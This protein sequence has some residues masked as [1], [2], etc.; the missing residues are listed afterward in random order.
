[1]ET[2]LHRDLKLFYAD[3]DPHSQLEVQLGKWRIDVV[4]GD[5]LIEIQHASLGAIRNKVSALLKHHAVRVV[6]PLPVRRRL[7]KLSEPGGDVTSRR[8]SPKRG[9]PLDLFK[10]LIHFGEVFPHPRLK[11]DVVFC[12]IEEQRYPGHGRRRWRRPGDFIVQDRRLLDV[13][14][15]R[16]LC[17]ASDLRTFAD[18]PRGKAALPRPFDTGQ[19]A[20]ALGIDRWLAQQIAYCWR[21]AGTVSQVGKQGNAWLY[22]FPRRGKKQA[23]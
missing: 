5:E 7:V 14:E 4:R 13:H 6:K 2:S 23:A 16:T 20:T 19:L 9:G 1:M 8:L 17:R 21:N 18:L 10:E 15:I 11:L 3:A 22:E 12:E